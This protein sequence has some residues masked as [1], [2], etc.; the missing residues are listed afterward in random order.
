VAVLVAP[1]QICHG[2]EEVLRQERE[3]VGQLW[4]HE[5]EAMARLMEREREFI[6]RVRG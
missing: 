1:L 3:A 5:R 2:A 6:R 4:E